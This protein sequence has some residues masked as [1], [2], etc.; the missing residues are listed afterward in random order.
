MIKIAAA[1]FIGCAGSLAAGC[2][3]F[4]GR[5]GAALFAW[6][7]LLA[8]LYVCVKPLYSLLALPLDMFLCGLG[9]LC[10]DALMIRLATPYG[11]S[12]WQALAVAAA[13]AVCFAPYEAWRA[14]NGV[15]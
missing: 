7:A 9:T 1:R 10:L 12:F 2:L 4:G 3:L 14:R 5:P 15:A 13:V 8:A 11:F 6:A